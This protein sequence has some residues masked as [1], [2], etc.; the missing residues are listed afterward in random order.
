MDL[1]TIDVGT[2]QG[3]AAL[4]KVVDG[5]LPT[6]AQLLDHIELLE[7]QRSAAREEWRTWLDWVEQKFEGE[8][9]E[10]LKAFD[11]FDALTTFFA[12]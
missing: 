8:D 1:Q 3:R 7:R 6:V 4:R 5:K 11:G 12:K 2:A 9:V 10:Q